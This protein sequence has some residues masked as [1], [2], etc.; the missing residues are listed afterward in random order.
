MKPNIQKIMNQNKQAFLSL[1]IIFI[2]LGYVFINN[3]LL[4]IVF[5]LVA[6]IISGLPILMRALS[7]LKFNIISIELL[8]SIAVVGALIIEEWS[9]AAIVTT[10][11][12]LGNYLEILALEKT[13]RSIKKLLSLKPTTA[14]KL[15]DGSVETVSID[16]VMADDNLIIKM[17][18]IIP[19]DGIIIKG[20]G[21]IN[22]ASITGESMFVEKERDHHVYAGTL[23]EDGMLTIKATKIGEDT[24]FSKI[25]EMVELAQDRKAPIE[26]VI[27]T[28]AKC[29]TP[30]VILVSIFTFVF[31]NNL[32]LSITILVLACPGALVIGV[33]VVNV[34]GIGRSAKSGIIF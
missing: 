3:T 26:K 24:T 4:K 2:G 14:H 5:F 8:V 31:T 30:F 32:R 27:D 15:I 16:N 33:P 17:G 1:A 9:E 19:V 13:R 22:E 25:I 23:L 28:F 10:L 29:Y 21:S 18:D 11:F 6:T 7:S 12:Q 34:A 20:M